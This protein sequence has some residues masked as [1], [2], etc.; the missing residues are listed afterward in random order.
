MNRILALVAVAATISLTTSAEAYFAGQRWQPCDNLP[1]ASAHQAPLDFVHI[2]TK[3]I[4][5]EAMWKACGIR[6]RDGVLYGCTYRVPRY[7]IWRIFLN[8]AMTAQET[9]CTMRIE[10]AH[11]PPNN[12][13]NPAVEGLVRHS[14]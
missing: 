5:G 3:T 7:Q 2:V 13:S 11:L 1:P 4:P 8:G 6:K 14:N 10:R 9:A 12:W